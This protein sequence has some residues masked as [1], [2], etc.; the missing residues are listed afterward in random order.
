MDKDRRKRSRCSHLCLCYVLNFILIVIVVIGLIVTIFSQSKSSQSCSLSASHIQ[1]LM[2]LTNAPVSDNAEPVDEKIF[3]GK[4][5]LESSENFDEF[6]SELGVGYLTRAVATRAK[7]QY[8]ITKN[9]EYYTLKTHS[10]FRTAEITFKLN[11]ETFEEE[12][13]DGEH[14]KSNMTMSGNKWIQ[15]QFG[16]KEVTYIREFTG[17]EVKLTAIVNNVI[18]VRVYKRIKDDE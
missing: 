4:F 6:L 3:L 8:E 18:T 9:G 13:L 2:N 15:R 11:G 16:E 14:V 7:S 5:E 10:P 12:R 1:N 17:D